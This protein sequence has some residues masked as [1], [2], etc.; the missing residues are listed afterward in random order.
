MEARACPRRPKLGPGLFIK[1]AAAF[2][3][4]CMV[5]IGVE[6]ADMLANEVLSR[7]LGDGMAYRPLCR[8]HRLAG[9]ERQTATGEG[10]GARWQCSRPLAHDPVAAS[11]RRPRTMPSCA[12]SASR[13][14]DGEARYED[15]RAAQPRAHWHVNSLASTSM[16]RVIGYA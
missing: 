11:N 15:R 3:Y 10:L 4:S 5:P 16:V 1:S 6:T 13:R 12:R 8:P 14:H 9:R 2:S 7:H